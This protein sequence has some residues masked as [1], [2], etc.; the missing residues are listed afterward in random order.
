M[1]SS[2]LR[3]SVPVSSIVLIIFIFF[4]TSLLIIH[5]QTDRIDTL[6][7]Q[8]DLINQLNGIQSKQI[9]LLNKAISTQA[10]Y[11]KQVIEVFE[12]QTQSD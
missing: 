8:V 1:K 9:E 11:N 4:V 2:I 3:E 5:V 6:Q 7:E 12:L 10:E